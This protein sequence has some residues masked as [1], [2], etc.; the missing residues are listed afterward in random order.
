VKVNL[1]YLDPDK[2]YSFRFI[3]KTTSGDVS[4]PVG[5]TKTTALAGDNPV[6]F[7][8]I[9]CSTFPFGRFHV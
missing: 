8:V 5:R 6:K 1:T 3:A 2:V 9:S 4:S 7:A